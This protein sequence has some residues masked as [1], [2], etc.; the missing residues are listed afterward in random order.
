MTTAAVLASILG[1]L[2]IGAASP[3]PSFVL[4]SRDA[5]SASRL[6]GLAAAVGMGVGGAFFAALA[7]FGL[8]ALLLQ[9]GWLYLGLKLAGGAYLVYLGLRIWR[10]AQQSLVLP[11]SGGLRRSLPRS[12]FLGLMTQVSNPKTALVYTSIFAALLPASPPFWLLISLVPLVASVE[13]GWY[14][15]VALAFSARKPRSAYLAAKLWID[16]AAGAVI[17]VLGLQ[18][19]ASAGR[20]TVER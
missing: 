20:A 14:A 16:R 3:G 12:F 4:V 10:G 18:L 11:D 13:A 1:A 15:V 19:I 8:T 6:D 2:L 7:V 17:G 5:I 9:V